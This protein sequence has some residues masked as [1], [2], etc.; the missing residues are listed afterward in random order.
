[1]TNILTSNSEQSEEVKT[2]PLYWRLGSSIYRTEADAVYDWKNS[3][4][5]RNTSYAPEP[6]YEQPCDLAEDGVCEAIDCCE[7]I[8]VITARKNYWIDQWSEV[9]NENQIL[10][11]QIKRNNAAMQQA[12][13]CLEDIF[14]KEKVDVGA[15]NLL[16]E[17]IKD[18]NYCFDV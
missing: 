2:A 1:M 8:T 13:Y 11:N 3:E 6:V 18:S 10:V 12:L 16:R 7:N 14:G 4:T 9:C 17:A 15:I 5:Y